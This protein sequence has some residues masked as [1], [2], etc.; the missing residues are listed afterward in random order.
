MTI[1]ISMSVAGVAVELMVETTL[2]AVYINC[3]SC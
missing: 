3:A 2:A 1:I